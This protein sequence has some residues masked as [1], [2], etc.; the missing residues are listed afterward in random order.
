MGEGERSGKIGVYGERAVEY[1]TS[2]MGRR[3]GT[4][5]MRILQ[6]FAVS[7]S[8]LNGLPLVTSDTSA[9]SS[10]SVLWST[11]DSP[12]HPS[13][14]VSRASSRSP[15]FFGPGNPFGIVSCLNQDRFPSRLHETPSF[16]DGIR[17]LC[18]RRSSSS[19]TSGY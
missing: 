4:E 14:L 9:A 6:R 10:M 19:Y 2:C 13:S 16:S 5:M 18:R 8:A 12:E 15:L 3:R 1:M 11:D 7:R 17:R